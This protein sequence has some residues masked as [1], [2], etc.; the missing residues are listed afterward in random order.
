VVITCDPGVLDGLSVVD[1]LGHDSL[2]I[3]NRR[4]MVPWESLQACLITA[5]VFSPRTHL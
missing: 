4:A 1:E 3:F 5:M 2:D